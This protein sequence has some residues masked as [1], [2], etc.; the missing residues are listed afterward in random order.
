[1]SVVSAPFGTYPSFAFTPSDDAII[2]W[3]AGQIWHV[4][5]DANSNGERVS[6]GEPKIIPFKARIEKRLAETRS[7]KTDIKSVETSDTQRV[8]AFYELR[9]DDK[10]EKVVFQASGATYVQDVQTHG[11]HQAQPVPVLH[12]NAPYFSPSFVPGRTD[13]VIHARWSDVNFTTFELANLSSGEAYEISGLP[14]GR[15]Y[16][17]VLCACSGSQ[18]KIAFLKT[19]EIGRAHV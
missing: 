4:P 1:M 14:L 15:Y 3:A 17:P 16:S 12:P 13:L 5:L 10:G 6:G 7:P 8:Y 9:V 11:T 19:A 2:I 18:R